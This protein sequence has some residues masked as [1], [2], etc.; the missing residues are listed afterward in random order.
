MQS[1]YMTILVRLAT[2]ESHQF[3]DQMRPSDKPGGNRTYYEWVQHAYHVNE[4][5]SLSIVRQVRE[6]WYHTS[7]E[8][9]DLT[10]VDERRVAV[11]PRSQWS[12]IQE[13]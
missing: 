5:R 7:G 11:Y 6:S 1:A 8:H 10:L 3:V 2:G 4:D 12:G 13:A 9:R